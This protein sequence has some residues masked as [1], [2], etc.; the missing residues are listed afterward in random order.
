MNLK[1]LNPSINREVLDGLTG[2]IINIMYTV[3]NTIY[4]GQMAGGRKNRTSNFIVI[5]CTSGFLPLVLG[6]GLPGPLVS[7]NVVLSVMSGTESDPH[8]V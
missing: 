4:Y 7:Q 5:F 3:I 2:C 1:V 6:F 8:L